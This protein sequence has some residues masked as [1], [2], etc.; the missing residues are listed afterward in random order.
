MMKLRNVVNTRN[1]GYV[2]IDTCYTFDHGFET[3][4][5]KCDKNGNIIDWSDLDV[6]MYDNAEK[7]EEGHKEMIEK[8]KT[9]KRGKIMGKVRQRLGKAYIHTK[10]ESIQS[11]IIDALVDHGYDVDVEVT[12]NGTGNEIV[13][14]EIYDVGGQ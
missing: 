3:M 14:C 9:N 5:F 11:I 1:H 12:D 7:A 2:A 13:S 8:W 6:D 4:V 10:E